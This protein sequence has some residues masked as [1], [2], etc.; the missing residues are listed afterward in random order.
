MSTDRDQNGVGRTS[1][2]EESDVER[3]GEFTID[4]AP[5]AWY[6]QGPAGSQPQ[7]PAVPPLPSGFTAAPPTPLAATGPGSNGPAGEASGGTGEVPRDTGTP[8]GGTDVTGGS[9]GTGEEPAGAGT[10][11]GGVDV[12]A[13]RSDGPASQGDFAVAAPSYNAPEPVVPA[14]PV[15]PA[16]PAAPA[17]PEPAPAP[18]PEPEPQPLAARAE[19][20]PAD[21]GVLDSPSTVRFSARALRREIAERDERA[22]EQTTLIPRIRVDEPQDAVPPAPAAPQPEPQDAPP[23]ALAEP[24]DAPPPAQRSPYSSDQSAAP[25]SPPSLP[26]PPAPQGEVP[27]LPP[28]FQPAAGA[29]WDFRAWTDRSR[30]N[31]GVDRL[32]LVQLHCPPTPVFSSDAVFDALDTL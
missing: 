9:S 11:A 8:A 27:P 5:S 7:D 32:D 29:P 3:T 14:E 16:A 19:P 18:A 17:A 15:A 22:E 31:L 4:Y 30:R 24:Q 20:E 6:T 12:S 10:P 26:A 28:Q 13:P 25:W 2:D 23:P 1:P 21:D